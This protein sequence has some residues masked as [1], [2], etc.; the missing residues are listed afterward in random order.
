MCNGVDQLLVLAMVIPPLM[1]TP[2]NG[3]TNPYKVNDHPYHRKT[4]GVWTHKK[5]VKSPQNSEPKWRCIKVL[6]PLSFLRRFHVALNVASPLGICKNC[7][8]SIPPWTEL[9]AARTLAF[10]RSCRFTLASETQ[11]QVLP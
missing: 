5:H 9:G 2:Y 4:M 1:G 11:V 3:Y 10:T 8:L 7:Q 6:Q